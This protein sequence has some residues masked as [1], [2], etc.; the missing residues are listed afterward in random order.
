[1]VRD[2]PV[3]VK[4]GQATQVRLRVTVDP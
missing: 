3:E 2:V 4:P 1:V